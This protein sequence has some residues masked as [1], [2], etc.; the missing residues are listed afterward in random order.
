M[1]LITRRILLGVGAALL[2]GGWG[3]TRYVDG[4]GVVFMA[5]GAG[6]IGFGAL[7]GNGRTTDE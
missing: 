1:R 5:A 2:V 7:R 4:I 3:V 6:C